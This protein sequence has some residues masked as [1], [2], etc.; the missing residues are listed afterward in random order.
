MIAFS[1][2]QHPL[3][4]N[5]SK[6]AAFKENL[7]HEIV[8]NDASKTV[9]FQAKLKRLTCEFR[10]QPIDAVW[11]RFGARLTSSKRSRLARTGVRVSL[12]MAIL[13]S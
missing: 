6:T 4:K 11:I 2:L 12:C 8:V 10:V 13:E 3:C 5:A 9:S 7:N 1:A